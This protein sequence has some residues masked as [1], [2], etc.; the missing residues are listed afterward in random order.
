LSPPS[1]YPKDSK[2]QASE[3]LKPFDFT[4][5]PDWPIN[6]PLNFDLTQHTTEKMPE[7]KVAAEPPLT[8]IK[9]PTITP[10]RVEFPPPSQQVENK[11]YPNPQIIS[12]NI[13]HQTIKSMKIFTSSVSQNPS[14]AFVDIKLS[15][16]TNIGDKSKCIKIKALHNR[17]CAKMVIKH[18]VFEHLVALG[19]IEIM[20]PECQIVLISCTGEA[21]PIEGSAHIILHF[22]GTNGI[23]TAYQ[24]NVLVHTALSQDFLLGRDFTGSDAK[25]FETNKHLYL[26]DNFDLFWDPNRTSEQ[27]KTLC[28]IPLLSTQGPLV[29]VSTNHATVI[30]PFQMSSIK[31][32]IHKHD[33][34][35]RY[36]PAYKASPTNYEVKTCS[37]K[38]VDALPFLMQFEE[39]HK[40]YI[41]V[42]YNT[43]E[44]II[45]EADTEIAE[46]KMY[47][48]DVDAEWQSE[49]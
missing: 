5:H 32:H 38:N 4:T 7:E 33:N 26:T 39:P 29:R 16:P 30:P 40:L 19:H 47:S 45:I 36:L 37:I 15:S 17:G 1:L 14:P 20:K 49:N 25:A 42:Y 21:Q 8:P 44:D 34:P 10:R 35:A 2:F 41:P 11:T 27:N 46:I 3:I 48:T 12:G 23:N 31:T 24:L 13:L 18:S 22:E 28:Q 6:P 43:L 9:N